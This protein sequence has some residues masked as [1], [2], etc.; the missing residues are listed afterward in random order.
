MV[1]SGVIGDSYRLLS[2]GDGSRSH[3]TGSLTIAGTIADVGL[4]GMNSCGV[5]QVVGR[6]WREWDGVSAAKSAC[7]PPR[8]PAKRP[9]ANNVLPLA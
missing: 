9:V 7:E 4:V 2:L 5:W 8:R 1:E 6:G 3:K